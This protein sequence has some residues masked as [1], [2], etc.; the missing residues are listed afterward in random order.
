MALALT[1]DRLGPGRDLDTTDLDWK[2]LEWL[3]DPALVS[4]SLDIPRSY[5]EPRLHCPLWRTLDTMEFPISKII[6]D[7][8]SSQSLAFSTYLVATIEIERQRWRTSKPSKLSYLMRVATS[9]EASESRDKVYSIHY[10]RRFALRGWILNIISRYIR[11][12]QT[13]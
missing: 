5:R 10:C 13:H 7:G 9:F 8:N 2:S 1:K 3:L 4:T 12:T 6:V 11:F